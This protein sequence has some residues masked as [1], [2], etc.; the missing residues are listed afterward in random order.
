[1]EIPELNLCC[2]NQLSQRYRNTRNA[3]TTFFFASD[4]ACRLQG[5]SAV[6]CRLLRRALYMHAIFRRVCEWALQYTVCV[7]VCVY[8]CLKVHDGVERRLRCVRDESTASLLGAVSLLPGVT[9]T[10]LAHLLSSL[11]QTAA[12]HTH[13]H[14][15]THKLQK[16]QCWVNES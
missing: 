6:F 8:V 4:V 12:I 5:E 7:C 11:R 9:S 16:I 1:M 3:K 15:H 2:S 13:T 14:T 10:P